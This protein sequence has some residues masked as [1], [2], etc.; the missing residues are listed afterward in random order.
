MSGVSRF[1]IAIVQV[2]KMKILILISIRSGRLEDV[3]CVYREREKGG[4]EKG[5]GKEGTES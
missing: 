2:W 5:K 4:R 3:G 1:E